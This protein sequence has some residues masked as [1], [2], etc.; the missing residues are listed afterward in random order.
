MA[1]DG[2]KEIQLDIGRVIE[3]I[4]PNCP[5]LLELYAELERKYKAQNGNDVDSNN[6]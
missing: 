5:N 2:I 4:A 1:Y 6:D 3:Q